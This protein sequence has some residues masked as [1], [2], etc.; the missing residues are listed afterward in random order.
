M[1]SHSNL[2]D[3]IKSK[4]YLLTVKKLIINKLNENLI[5]IIMK[6]TNIIIIPKEEI[7]KMFGLIVLLTNRIHYMYDNKISD[8]MNY[9]NYNLFQE[10]KWKKNKFDENKLNDIYSIIL[11]LLESHFNLNIK[12]IGTYYQYNNEL[13][14]K[15]NKNIYFEIIYNKDKYISF[16]INKYW[17]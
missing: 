5:D 7:K 6:Y 17:F 15:T 11:Y 8:W 10:I 13:T 3:I 4:E 2:N 14:F 12:K 16:K 1:I 9:Y